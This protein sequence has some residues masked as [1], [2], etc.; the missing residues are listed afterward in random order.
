MKKRVR[1]S[2]RKRDR[3]SKKYWMKEGE[4]KKER[5]FH[6]FRQADIAYGC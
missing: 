2:K 1:E 6:G 5:V 3:K 4:N